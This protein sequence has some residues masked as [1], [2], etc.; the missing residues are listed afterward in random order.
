MPLRAVFFDLDDTLCDSIGARPERARRAF[1]RLRRDHPHLDVEALIARA[2]EPAGP[3]IV[4]GVPAVLEELGV[5]DTPAG[6]EA[7][8]IWWFRPSERL[9]HCF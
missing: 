4:R 2:L 7:L 9:L 5:K 8:D 3:R 1:Q 6:R